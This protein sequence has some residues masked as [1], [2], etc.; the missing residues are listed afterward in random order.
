MAT[1]ILVMAAFGL[2]LTHASSV[3]VY[4]AAVIVIKTFFLFYSVVT[5]GLFASLDPSGKMNGMGLAFAVVGTS[6]G[7]SYGGLVVDR[8]EIRAYLVGSLCFLG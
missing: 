6:M 8:P 1:A 5:N 4:G 3:L 7:P 2:L